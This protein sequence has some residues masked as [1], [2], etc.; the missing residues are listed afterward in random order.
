[1]RSILFLAFLVL[2]AIAP[3]ADAPVQ[4]APVRVKPSDFYV[5]IEYAKDTQAV[6]EIRVN[7]V[8]PGSGAEKRGIRKG[9]RIVAIDGVPVTTLKREV[10]IRDGRVLAREELSFEGARGFLRK[11]WSLTVTLSPPTQ[12]GP[13]KA[14]ATAAENKK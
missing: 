9:D 3:A 13:N 14:P 5:D 6:V 10:V 12:N 7:A 8:A 11:K 4:M 1:M 2:S